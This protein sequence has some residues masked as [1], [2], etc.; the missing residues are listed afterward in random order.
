[1]THPALVPLAPPL[2]AADAGGR[3]DATRL[4][5]LDRTRAALL[6]R[7]HRRPGDLA[8]TV[9]LQAVDAESAEITSHADSHES[10]RLMRGGLSSNESARRWLRSLF[11]RGSTR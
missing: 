11:R 5:A 6:V 4:R 7:L 1:V 9:E 8:A 3:D 10:D 2:T